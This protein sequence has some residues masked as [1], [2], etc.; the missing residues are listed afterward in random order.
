MDESEIMVSATEAKRLGYC[1]SGARRT[2]KKHN[3]DFKYYLKHGISIGTL[4]SFNEPICDRLAEDFLAERNLGD[5]VVTMRDVKEAGHC[6][7]GAI[8]RLK[9]L[10]IDWRDAV[11]NG[12]PLKDLRQI[13]NPLVQRLVADLEKIYKKA[14]VNNGG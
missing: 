13:E 7:T 8:A 11:R 1:Y 10:N 9:E 5:I 6:T 12:V 14:G 2:L 3:Y 4:R